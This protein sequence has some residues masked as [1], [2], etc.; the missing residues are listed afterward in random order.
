MGWF[1]GVKLMQK[2]ALLRSRQV[3]N[4]DLAGIRPKSVY[5]FGTTGCKM[6]VTEFTGDSELA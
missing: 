5:G 4:F 6:T 1:C 2:N 3:K